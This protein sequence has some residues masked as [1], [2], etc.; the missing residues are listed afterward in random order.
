MAPAPGVEQELSRVRCELEAEGS[1]EHPK[2]ATA[3]GLVLDSGRPCSPWV[4]RGY[5]YLFHQGSKMISQ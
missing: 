3:A 5:W 1:Q 4:S 2:A